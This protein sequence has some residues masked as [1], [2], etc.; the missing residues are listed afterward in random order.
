[1][2]RDIEQ[3]IKQIMDEKQNGISFKL[4]LFKAVKKGQY[5]IIKLLIEKD[6]AN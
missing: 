5:E 4:Q 6:Y 2:L 1:M 3:L